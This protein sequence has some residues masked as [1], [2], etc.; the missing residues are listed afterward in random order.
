MKESTKEIIHRLGTDERLRKW[1]GCC[2][3]CNFLFVS[4]GMLYGGEYE[5]SDDEHDEF[6]GWLLAEHGDDENKI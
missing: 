4:K 6:A 3:H 2:C 1:S 5:L